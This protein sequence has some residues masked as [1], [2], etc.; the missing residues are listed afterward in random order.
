MMC[1]WDTL[2]MFRDFGVTSWASEVCFVWL[3]TCF[4]PVLYTECS[5]R[6]WWRLTN[7]PGCAAPSSLACAMALGVPLPDPLQKG[8]LVWAVGEQNSGRRLAKWRVPGS[9]S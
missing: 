1:K 3:C 5:A 6:P 8:L 7:T 4:G 2:F 9:G